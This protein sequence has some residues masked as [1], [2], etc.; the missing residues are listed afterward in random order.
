MA[1][2]ARDNPAGPRGHCGKWEVQEMAKVPLGGGPF[3]GVK[4]FEMW[5]WQNRRWGHEVVAFCHG[6]TVLRSGEQILNS[7][8]HGVQP[9]AVMDGP[10]AVAS[11]WDAKRDALI[12]Q[13]L[14]DE[15]WPTV[16]W[17]GPPRKRWKSFPCSG[18]I[19]LGVNWL[20]KKVRRD[21]GCGQCRCCPWFGPR[22]RPP[23]RRG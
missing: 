4:T 3:W 1:P 6:P 20:G 23:D 16:G 14:T 18:G 9:L 19:E 12:R 11:G 10:I 15:G 5:G 17:V 7:V 22:S 13:G 2:L 8:Q 21:W